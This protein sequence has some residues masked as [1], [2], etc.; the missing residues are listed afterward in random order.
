MRLTFGRL[1]NWSPL[2][3]ISYI[4]AKCYARLC[5]QCALAFGWGQRA[6]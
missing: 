4:V 3:G 5:K 1:R 6:G 2:D